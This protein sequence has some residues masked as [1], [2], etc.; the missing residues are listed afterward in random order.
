MTSFTRALHGLDARSRAGLVCIR[1]GGKEVLMSRQL[2]RSSLAASLTA[3]AAASIPAEAA[4]QI[5]C[6]VPFSFTVRGRTLPPGLYHA[7]T[8]AP[9]GVLSIRG[10]GG[11]ALAMAIGIESGD[12]TEPKLVFHKY[13]D[14]YYLQEVWLGGGY[15]RELLQNRPKGEPIKTAEGGPAAETFERVVIA[16]R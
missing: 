14:E 15:G 2:L 4:H 13:G 16:A 5:R 3:L 11:F 1:K 9:Q 7:S 8:D 10:D 12:V 6:Q